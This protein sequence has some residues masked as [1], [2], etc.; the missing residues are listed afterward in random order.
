MSVPANP[1]HF[2]GGTRRHIPGG[3][4]AI[5]RSMPL[6]GNFRICPLQSIVLAQRAS[7]AIQTTSAS[8]SPLHYGN[9]LMPFS[10]FPPDLFAVARRY[11]NKWLASHSWWVAIAWLG[12]GLLPYA[13]SEKKKDPRAIPR[14][15]LTRGHIETQR[16]PC[17]PFLVA[18]LV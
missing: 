15:R 9:P 7:R 14:Q 4:T 16:S 5:F 1:P 18:H 6:G 13:S 2:L 17:N 3:Q 8:V 12:R 11:L 10:A